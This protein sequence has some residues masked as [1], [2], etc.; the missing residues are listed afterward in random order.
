MV[1]GFVPG[2][3]L[4]TAPAVEGAAAVFED[5]AA[6]S[7]AL[8][9]ALTRSCAPGT[10]PG[11]P[12]G[13][14]FVEFEHKNDMKEAYKMAEGRKLDGRRILVDV[15]RGRV[16]PGWCA[17]FLCWARVWH[18]AVGGGDGGSAWLGTPPSQAGALVP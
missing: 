6:A 7:L 15:E 11:K 17:G 10:R 4:L 16:V 3:C 18:T 1:F 8:L 12:R 5:R 2:A 9:P 13:Y 14:A